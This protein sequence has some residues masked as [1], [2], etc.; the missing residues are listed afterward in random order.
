MDH[1]THTQKTILKQRGAAVVMALFVVVLCTLA[2]SPLIW[3]LF[4]TAKTIAVAAARDQAE[5]VSRSGLDWARVILRE[6]ARVSATDTLTEPWAVP[7]AESRL[8]E[9][10]M[11]QD[12]NATEADDREVVLTGRIEDAQG[13]F[14]LRN[15]GADNPRQANWLEAF[16]KLCDLLGVASD[17]RVLIAQTVAQ[18]YATPN[19]EQEKPDAIRLQPALRWDEFLGKYGVTEE[20][21]NQLRPYVAILPKASG[22]N[23]NT[24]SAEVLYAVVADMSFG[25]AQRLVVQRERVSFRNIADVRSALN[26]NINING[27]MVGVASSYFLVEG[28]AQVEEALIRTRA[29]LERRDQRVYVMWRQ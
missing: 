6:D 2:V 7:L 5:A 20:T 21:W 25:D 17:Q 28:T 12:Q 15:L 9:G 24:A 13:R 11:R 8:N 22:V 18:M 1:T 10:L 3:N 19:P 14:N 29:L 26:A 16:G 4:A 23:A 27:D